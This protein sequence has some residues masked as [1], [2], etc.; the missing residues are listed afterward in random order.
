MRRRDFLGVLGGAAALPLTVLAQQPERMRRIGMLTPLKES[1]YRA[2]AVYS[3]FRKRLQELGWS[4]GR[5]LQIDYRWGEGNP[6]LTRAYAA[7][8]VALKPDALHAYSTPVV[9][10]LQQATSS[11]PIVFVGLSDPV[12][13]GFVDSFAHPGRNAT[14]FT[15]YVPTISS[16]WLELLKDVAP[17]INRVAAL[18]NPITAPYATKFYIPDLKNA[19]KAMATE[20]MAASVQEPTEIEAAISEFVRERGGG[21]I[22]IPDTFTIVNRQLI[23]ALADKFRLPA[24][25]PY[26]YVGQEGGLITYGF[27]E[28]EPYPRSAEYIDRILKGEKPADLPVQAPTKYELVINLKTAKTLGLTVPPTLLG[29]ADEVIE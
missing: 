23:I 10:A 13:S 6:N 11:I 19:G 28:I 4:V 25:Y 17:R 29:R 16:K 22:V 8:L 15:N 27:N 24:I 3:A 20:V 1:D 26:R 2:Q 14:G 18:F 21:L 9:A 12:G 5:N 7:E